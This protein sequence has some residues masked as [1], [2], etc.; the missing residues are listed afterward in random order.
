[1]GTCCS[2][3]CCPTQNMKSGWGGGVP[4]QYASGYVYND[5]DP[6][7][8]CCK[9]VF[10][11]DFCKSIDSKYP[12]AGSD[13]GPCNCDPAKVMIQ[14]AGFDNCLKPAPPVALRCP[15]DKPVWKDPDDGMCE[16]ICDKSPADCASYQTFRPEFCR[17]I[18][19]KDLIVCDGGDPC[20][21]APFLENPT[22]NYHPE[23]CSCKCDLSPANGG[24][25]CSSNV[26]K[27]EFNADKCEC[28][29]RYDTGAAECPP[30]L[31]YIKEDACACECPYSVS[32]SCTSDQIFDPETCSCKPCPSPCRG[33]NTRVPGTCDC[34]CLRQTPD[35]PRD[36]PYLDLVE[37]V[38]YCPSYV[39]INCRGQHRRFDSDRCAC[40]E[41]D[42]SILSILLEP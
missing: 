1:M 29:C 11:D 4:P 40:G 26:R 33:G 21:S 42:A 2:Q 22:P 30:N 14:R 3:D 18:C 27:P 8:P 35:C 15:P 13:C 9:C 28:E 24:P 17:C 10:T 19:E 16:C 7:E 12:H 39:A 32:E 38:C 5:I 37:C 41:Y 36:E 20:D 34:E 23:D 6:S 31:P 25:G